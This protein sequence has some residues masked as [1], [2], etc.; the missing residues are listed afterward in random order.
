MQSRQRDGMGG[1]GRW[2]RVSRGTG[3]VERDAGT[4]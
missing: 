2:Y 3:W 4:G 1:E